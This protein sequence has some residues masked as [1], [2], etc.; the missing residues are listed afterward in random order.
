MQRRDI[1][2]LPFIALATSQLNANSIDKAITKNTK[3]KVV[4]IG[5]GFGGLTFAKKFKLLQKDIEVTVIDKNEIFM[6]GPMFNLM[7]GEI[8]GV[9]FNTIIHD[10]VK[11]ALKYNYNLHYGEV[12]KIDRVAKKVY[13]TNGE[14][15]YTYLILSPGIDY[16]YEA[17]FPK[18]D[19]TKIL[20]AKLQAPP[21]L[22]PGSEF[23]TLMQNLKS[24]KGGNIIVTVPMGEYRC[25]PAPYERAC[26]FAEYIKKNKLNGKVIVIDNYSRPVSKTEAFEEAFKEI[27]PD[28]IEYIG[29]CNL[30]DVDF[31]NKK[32]IYSYWGEGSGD[33][34]DIKEINYEILNLI[35][36]NKTSEV[37]KM[38]NIKTL[39]WGSAKLKKPTYQSITDENVYVIGDC[40]GYS[41]P[42][43]GQMANSM[44]SICAKHLSQ[45]INKEIIT[46][47]MPG[48]ICISMVND[49]EAISDSHEISYDGVKFKVK[50]FMPYDEQ[51]KKYRSIGITDT[52]FSWYGG[53]MS[54]MLD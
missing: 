15:D 38:A 36:N 29:D 52:L 19:K 8:D 18:W 22:I 25:P 49:T 34:G 39:S 4:V 12:Y 13:T 31:E 27:Y 16:N 17:Q 51:T 28:I 1:L 44:A 5:G 10:R 48:N 43:S 33:D 9:T 35:A 53:I 21:A 50:R 42:E 46:Q 14:F 26:M 37:I 47:D 41:F 3:T 24:F 23:V 32:L 30:E 6:T 40:V 20:K 7:I 11:P 2:K 45:R 54:D